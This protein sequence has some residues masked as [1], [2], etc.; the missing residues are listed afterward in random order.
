M[1]KSLDCWRQDRF[2][3]LLRK[4]ELRSEMPN[5]HSEFII[6]GDKSVKDLA[7]EEDWDAVVAP[8]L[9]KISTLFQCH[10]N[11]RMS[12]HLLNP[13]VTFLCVFMNWLRDHER[14][15]VVPRVLRQVPKLADPRDSEVRALPTVDYPKDW[16]TGLVPWAIDE[17]LMT[18]RVPQGTLQ[19]TH[20]Q[21]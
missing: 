13:T 19:D 16:V 3:I 10:K 5:W 7:L 17:W 2:D 1:R 12:P 4:S 9:D 20:A 15:G 6:Q 21:N 14:G 18:A 11:F 8:V